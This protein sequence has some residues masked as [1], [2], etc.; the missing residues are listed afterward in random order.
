MRRGPTPRSIEIGSV[1]EINSGGL[2]MTVME[3]D[4][5]EAVCE[6]FENGQ[7]NTRHFPLAT[8]RLSDI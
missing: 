5:E 3:L 7:H 8:I 6:W 4:E 1:V 2:P